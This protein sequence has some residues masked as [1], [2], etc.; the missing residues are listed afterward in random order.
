MLTG[1]NARTARAIGADLG[2]EVHAYLLPED[3]PRM[4]EERRT[5]SGIVAKVSD[6]I[7][8][9]PTKASTTRTGLS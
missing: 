9:A 8:D 5:K 6:G 4:V 7:N 3:K 1:V 2:V